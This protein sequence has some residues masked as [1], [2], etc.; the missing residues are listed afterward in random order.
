[1]IN[2]DGKCFSSL[3]AAPENLLNCLTSAPIHTHHLILFKG[4]V[5]L[6]EAHYFSIM[7][8]LR[9]FRVEIP[10]HFTL[11]FFQ[12]QTDR[13]NDFINN[14]DEFQSLSLKFYRK[15][16][17]TKAEGVSPICFLMQFHETSWDTRTLDLILYKDHC[18][19]ANDYSN[20]FQTNSALRELGQV[21]A[22]E[23]GFGAAL[24]LNDHK[25]LA[26]STL[27]AVFLIQSDGIQTP[28]LSE[29]TANTV[30]RTAF[31]EFLKKDRKIEGVEAQIAVFSIQ[32]AEE[33][34]LISSTYGFIHIAQ[35]RKKK[36][37]KEKSESLRHQFLEYLKHQL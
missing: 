37:E 24:I 34:F 22:N 14:A 21:F 25:R 28:A 36:F 6:I 9:R 26:E 18:V 4:K 30:L 15:K 27:G 33:V 7:A 13:L 35:F 20:L 10:M 29:G 32:Q 31:I 12:E 3:G 2:F 23:N 11:N 8:A 1:M 17:P 19:F 16:N 5:S